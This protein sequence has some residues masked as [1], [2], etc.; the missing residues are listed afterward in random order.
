[1]IL[2]KHSFN[3]LTQK[4][5]VQEI[6][7]EKKRSVYMVKNRES[8]LHL[9]FA[10]RDIGVLK[11]ECVPCMYTL[12]SD[13]TPF[14]SALLKSNKRQI[15]EMEKGLKEKK[16]SHFFLLHELEKRKNPN[17]TYCSPK[18]TCT[19][20]GDMTYEAGKEYRYETRNGEY[21]IFI[22]CGFLY[23]SATEFHKFFFPLSE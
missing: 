3:E 15:E 22:D 14:L 23:F 16:K 5:E 20:N 12:S 4:I 18:V 10:E 8:S 6:E 7:V 1:M 9:R 19:F 17:S 21:K 13:P 11:R 2:Y